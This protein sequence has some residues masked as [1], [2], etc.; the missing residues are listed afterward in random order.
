M[1]RARMAKMPLS[2]ARGADTNSIVPILS[3]MSHCNRTADAMTEMTNRTNRT[4]AVAT[5]HALLRFGCLPHLQ[6]LLCT[7]PL[8][9]PMV[10]TPFNSGIHYESKQDQAE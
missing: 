1:H 2:T 10:M 9:A 8:H 4:V 5:G 6:W 7:C 3:K